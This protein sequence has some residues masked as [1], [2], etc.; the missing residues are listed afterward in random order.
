MFCTDRRDVEE[1]HRY[2]DI[3]FPWVGMILG[4]KKDGYILAYLDPHDNIPVF[5]QTGVSEEDIIPADEEEEA[6][7]M[8]RLKPKVIQV[9]TNVATLELWGREYKIHR[10]VH[11]FDE[12]GFEFDDQGRIKIESE[13][14]TT[15][16]LVPPTAHPKRHKP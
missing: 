10:S 8:E 9:L 3:G 6:N 7:L 15:V 14:K 5:F 12:K 2:A 16:Y 4:K 11:T 1:C 13:G